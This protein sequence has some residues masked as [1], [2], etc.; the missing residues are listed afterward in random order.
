MYV[1]Y[2]YV[3]DYALEIGM[4]NIQRRVYALA[5]ALRTGLRGLGVTVADV[6]QEQCGIVTWHAQNE[7]YSIS[8]GDFKPALAMREKRINVTITGPEST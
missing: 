8:S 2:M 6:G 5:A 1:L 7:K 3:I 4:E